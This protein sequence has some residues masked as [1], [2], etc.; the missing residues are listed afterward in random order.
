MMSTIDIVRKNPSKAILADMEKEEAFFLNK[1]LTFGRHVRLTCFEQLA[2]GI[3]GSHD[4]S[5][6]ECLWL[7]ALMQWGASLEDLGVWCLAIQKAT[8]LN[9][10]KPILYTLLTYSVG[11]SLLDNLL[12]QVSSFEEFVNKI[13]LDEGSFESM[14][15]LG[16][17]EMNVTYHDIVEWLKIFFE[18]LPNAHGSRSPI[19]QGYNQLKH[20]AVVGRWKKNGDNHD[21]P[22]IYQLANEQF[23]AREIIEYKSDYAHILKRDIQNIS[24]IIASLITSYI[25]KKYPDMIIKTEDVIT[26]SPAQPE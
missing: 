19:K 3:E 18:D 17:A 14:K 6:R 15:H 24:R 8:D 16:L 26:F 9:E 10:P 11:E 5:E 12:M 20:G 1:Y 21:N 23:I 2:K 22:T 25:L 7:G 13:G 4:Q